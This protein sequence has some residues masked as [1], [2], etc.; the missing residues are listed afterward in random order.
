MACNFVLFRRG[1]NFSLHTHTIGFDGRNTPADMVAAAQRVG[2]KHLG[3]SNHFIVHPNITKAKFYPFAV[4]DGYQSIY[5][6][7]FDEAVA[8]FQP[9]YEELKKLADSSD[10]KI[11]RGMEVDFFEYPEWRTGFEQAIK[12]LK[13][14]YTIGASHFVEMDG[15]LYNIHDFANADNMTRTMLLISYWSKLGRAAESGLFNFMAHLDLPKKTGC[16]TE[17]CWA[18][19]EQAAIERIAKS[20]TP[21]EIN[22]SFYNR[23]DEP[24]PSARILKMAAAANVPVLLSDDA[25]QADFV[26]RHFDR[27]YEFARNCGVK[28]FLTCRAVLR[29]SR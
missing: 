25:H 29:K 9:H 15:G 5:S 1:Q 4:R 27:A 2:L 6:S 11:Y 18:A 14:D 7:S 13:P 8:K 16:G 28:K 22:T 21:I 26:G 20:K 17:D 3:I 23:S 12:V 19:T 24:Y 10:I